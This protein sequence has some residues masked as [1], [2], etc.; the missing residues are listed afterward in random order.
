MLDL[1]PSV[2][3]M[4]LFCQSITVGLSTGMQGLSIINPVRNN[5]QVCV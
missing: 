1:D 4:F 2:L 3:F 5:T